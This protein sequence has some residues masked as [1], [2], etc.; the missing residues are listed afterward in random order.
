MS[1]HEF[2]CLVIMP[3]NWIELFKGKTQLNILCPNWFRW[4]LPRR[5]SNFQES[6]IIYVTSKSTVL[7]FFL[8]FPS[9]QSFEG[10]TRKKRMETERQRSERQCVIA[11]LVCAFV[12]YWSQHIGWFQQRHSHITNNTHTCAVLMPILFRFFFAIERNGSLCSNGMSCFKQVQM[13]A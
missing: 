12:Y 9:I 7:F 5:L 4:N 2:A 13:I 6:T 10:W 11:S 3:S 1:E 8:R